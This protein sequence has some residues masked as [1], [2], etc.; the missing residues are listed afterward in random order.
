MPAYIPDKQLHRGCDLIHFLRG[1]FAMSA[2]TAQFNPQRSGLGCSAHNCR[3]TTV[4]ER[5]TA[6]SRLCFRRPAS[7]SS[8]LDGPLPG[9]QPGDTATRRLRCCCGPRGTVVLLPCPAPIRPLVR[10]TAALL[11][12]FAFPEQPRTTAIRLPRTAVG[13]W[14]R[15]RHPAH[16]FQGST[17]HRMLQARPQSGPLSRPRENAVQ[18]TVRQVGQRLRIP[19]GR[20]FAIAAPETQASA[21]NLSRASGART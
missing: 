9:I 8:L 15:Q 3:S 10:S 4:K 12:I 1:R 14:Q 21:A 16:P 13:S 17:R 2:S 6:L 7:G 18:R 19:G 11:R 20:P 5:A